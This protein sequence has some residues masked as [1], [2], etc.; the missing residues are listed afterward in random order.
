MAIGVNPKNVL[1]PIKNKK[2]WGHT[3]LADD[4]KAGKVGNIIV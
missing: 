3:K 1:F 4:K 2:I